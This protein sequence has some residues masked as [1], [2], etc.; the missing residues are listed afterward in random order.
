VLPVEVKTKLVAVQIRDV[1][2]L[3]DL[4]TVQVDTG[5]RRVVKEDDPQQQLR[6]L[7]FL[8][9]WCGESYEMRL[10]DPVKRSNPRQY[11][12]GKSTDCGEIR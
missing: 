10:T 1:R 4:G 5:R 11:T 8:G 3:K 7:P 6:K 12:E 2:E 9:G